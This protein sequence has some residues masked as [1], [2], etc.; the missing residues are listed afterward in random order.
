MKQHTDALVA[1]DEKL[2]QFLMWVSQKSLSVLADFH[3]RCKPAAVRA[4]YFALDRS[5]DRSLDPAI[6][7]GVNSIFD[8]AFRDFNRGCDRAFAAPAFDLAINLGLNL[9]LERTSYLNCDFVDACNRTFTMAYTQ[10][11][12]FIIYDSEAELELALVELQYQLKEV[13]CQFRNLCDL[14]LPDID[15]EGYRQWW[16][17]NTQGWTEQLRDVMIKHRNIGHDWQF[18]DKQKE[19]LREY[20]DANKLLVDCLNSASN[21][22]PEVRSHIEETLLLPIVEIE[23]YR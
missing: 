4:F 15:D 1:S 21:V 19:L 2:Q 18:S 11:I 23:K 14:Q 20:Y 17:A 12:D 8:Q 13:Q 22:T 16:R 10:S 5:L 7:I 6:D 3:N 9:A